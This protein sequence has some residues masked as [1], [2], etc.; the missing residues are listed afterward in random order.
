MLEA[1]T[2]Q[3]P[4]SALRLLPQGRVEVVS[5]KRLH[6]GD[7]LRIPVGQPFAADGVLTEGATAA[8]EALLT[9]ESHPVAKACGAAVVAGSVNLLAPVVMRVQRVG[10]DTRYEAIVALMREARTQRPA[11]LATAD[12][13]AAPFL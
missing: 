2:A 7:L 1:T 12:R 4:D 5:V 9:G 8:D 3:L 10:A 11:L 13:W 6:A